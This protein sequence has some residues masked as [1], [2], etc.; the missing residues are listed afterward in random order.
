MCRKVVPLFS[1]DYPR[2]FLRA[3]ILN[4]QE[5]YSPEE[6]Y[7]VGLLDPDFPQSEL[8]KYMSKKKMVKLEK[9]LNPLT[10]A[11]VTDNK[12]IFYAYCR[13]LG[14]PV[15]TLY[16]IF[17][18]TTA[19]WSF[20]GSILKSR[21]DWERFLTEDL[22]SEFVVKPAR[23][24]YGV[25]VNVFVKGETGGF[26]DGSG[27]SYTAGDLYDMMASDPDF[28]SFVIQER[29]RNHPELVRLSGTEYLQTVRV[30]T[31]VDRTGEC[32]IY[33]AHLKAIV[34]ENVIDNYDHGRTG[35]LEAA[36]SR[37][38]GTLKPALTM[39]ESGMG[40]KTV[41]THPAT[42]MVFEGFRL[43]LW[44]ETCALAREAAIK[45]L[46]SRA[47]GWDVALTPD[48]PVLIEGNW[49]ADPLA[50]HQIMDAVLDLLSENDQ[51]SSGDRGRLQEEC[52]NRDASDGGS[53]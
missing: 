3:L 29:V 27:T 30:M 11:P 44:P 50:E 7:Q 2:I 16:A 36:I 21:E 22:P 12:G 23:G 9:S 5:F 51:L 24:Y 28:D 19:G 17:F 43:P 48:G 10:W 26:I 33:H 46:P 41:E 34:G 40:M 45:F 20:K 32:H 4:R 37:D 25:R 49:N 31:F 35:N 1:R 38:S 15:P 6:A 13:A 53:K 52:V 47:F 18:Q 42:G 39:R 8:R 14:I